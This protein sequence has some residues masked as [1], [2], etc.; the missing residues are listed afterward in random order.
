MCKLLRHRHTCGHSNYYLL[1]R[2]RGTY[3]RSNAQFTR[4]ACQAYEY[5]CLKSAIRCGPCQFREWDAIWKRRLER[6]R[7]E[8]TYVQDQGLDGLQESMDSVEHAESEYNTASWILRQQFPQIARRIYPRPKV[9]SRVTQWSPLRLELM[10]HDLEFEDFEDDTSEST[11]PFEHHPTF[12]SFFMDRY[13]YVGPYIDDPPELEEDDAI[14]TFEDSATLNEPEDGWVAN[15]PGLAVDIGTEDP[16]TQDAG[17]GW[18]WDAA[19]DS[20]VPASAENEDSWSQDTRTEWDWDGNDR[21]EPGGEIPEELPQQDSPLSST[22]TLT[23]RGPEATTKANATATVSMQDGTWND[24]VTNSEPISSMSR[25]SSALAAVK[26]LSIRQKQ[27]LTVQS[28]VNIIDRSTPSND[29]SQSINSPPNASSTTY[30]KASYSFHSPSATS[31]SSVA[32]EDISRPLSPAPAPKGPQDRQG[33]LN[34]PSPTPM[35]YARK[36]KITPSVFLE[37]QRDE[38][39]QRERK[40]SWQRTIETPR[41]LLK[42]KRR[43]DLP[44]GWS[45]GP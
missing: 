44:N 25:I 10:P 22:V 37:A 20:P 24:I 26:Q 2:C 32:T 13:G 16:W 42:E 45:S 34:I 29:P 39:I 7:Q 11:V 4:A 12:Q 23:T 30:D 43:P 31:S 28:L 6:A 15:D 14:D 27:S 5:L 19:G 38:A 36:H 18:N 33:D 35:D 40:S 17:A 3:R 9:H 41:Q 8:A 1:S 21:R